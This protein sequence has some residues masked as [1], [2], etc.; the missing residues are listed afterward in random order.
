MPLSS[1]HKHTGLHREEQTAGTE[2]LR[3][4]GQFAGSAGPEFELKQDLGVAIP[5]YYYYAPCKKCKK[6]KK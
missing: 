3:H 2:H 5:F 1:T 4:H 6:N